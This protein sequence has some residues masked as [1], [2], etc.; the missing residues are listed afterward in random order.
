MGHPINITI[1]QCSH[2]AIPQPVLNTGDLDCHGNHINIM[3]HLIMGHFISHLYTYVFSENIILMVQVR[4]LILET[5]NS[6][7]QVHLDLNSVQWTLILS[8]S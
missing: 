3:G 6:H 5:Q 2:G 7:S 4:I 8:W 1:K